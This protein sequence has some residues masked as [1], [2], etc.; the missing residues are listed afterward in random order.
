MN[1]GDNPLTCSEY[2]LNVSLITKQA[3]PKIGEA[4]PYCKQKTNA[5]LGHNITASFLF[6]NQY[7]TAAFKE[8]LITSSIL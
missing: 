1:L 2:A 7:V 5:V 8:F 3:S 4:K 6:E